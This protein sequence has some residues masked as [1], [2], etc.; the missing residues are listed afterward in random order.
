MLRAGGKVCK[1]TV[2]DCYIH[3]ALSQT[4]ACMH[5]ALR[6]PEGIQNHW[7]IVKAYKLPGCHADPMAAMFLFTH[8]EQVCK[9]GVHMFLKLYNSSPFSVAL[10]SCERADKTPL[11]FTRSFSTARHCS[12][13]ANNTFARAV[14]TYTAYR[15][16]QRTKPHYVQGCF[17]SRPHL[18]PPN[19]CSP[20]CWVR[21]K[22]IKMMTK[23]EI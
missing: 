10:T 21:N 9:S 7:C 8:P 6:K 22:K 1:Y 15:D 3:T 11:P 14:L 5:R 20:S 19:D 2:S 23:V 17:A 16:L 4:E 18:I 13:N 12:G